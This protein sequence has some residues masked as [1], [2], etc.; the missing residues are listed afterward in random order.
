MNNE[1]HDRYSA[2]LSAHRT[3]KSKNFAHQTLFEFYTGVYLHLHL[4]TLP[5]IYIY[6]A[7]RRP[8]SHC[9]YIT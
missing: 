3:A 2:L 6:M 4:R 7:T 9:K 5:G 1:I 8:P